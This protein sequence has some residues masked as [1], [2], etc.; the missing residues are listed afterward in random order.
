MKKIL[1]VLVGAS[2]A[3]VPLGCGGGDD[4][5]GEAQAELAALMSSD[6]EFGVDTDC[7]SDKTGELSD[8]DA[9]FLIDN[10]DAE[11][12]GFSSELQVWVASLIDCVDDALLEE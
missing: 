12:D 3:F 1:T 5:D 11:A 4:S 7:I 2:L 8:D 10:I 9:Q 6:V